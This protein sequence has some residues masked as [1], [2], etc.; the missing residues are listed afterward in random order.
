MNRENLK[1]FYR[2]L[3][4]EGIIIILLLA[5]IIVFSFLSP[6]FLTPNNLINIFLNVAID[7]LMAIGVTL[8]VISGGID[9]SIGS[10]MALSATLAVKLQGIFNIFFAVAIAVFAGI[11]IGLINGLLVTRAKINPF[12]S[13]LGMFITLKGLVYLILENKALRTENILYKNITHGKLFMVNFPIWVFFIILIITYFLLSRTILGKRIYA[14][15]GDK[16]ISVLFGLNY[17]S[18]SLFVYTFSGFCAAVSG[19]ILSSRASMVSPLFG[20]TTMLMVI[21]AVVLGGVSL[22]GG[23]GTV[24]KS[25]IGIL[26]FSIIQNAFGLL[27]FDIDYQMGVWGALLVTIITISDFKEKVLKSNKRNV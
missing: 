18:I 16:F 26:I 4:D 14:I 12:I 27:G 8:V 5:L 13:T 20:E 10:V 3:I 7:G 17:N 25:F 21:G 11:I 2:Y 23:K 1:K 19:I 15:G 9:L 22:A 24:I 6:I